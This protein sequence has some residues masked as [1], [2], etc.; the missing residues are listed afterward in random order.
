L[1]IKHIDNHCSKLVCHNVHFDKRI[2]SNELIRANTNVADVETYCTMKQTIN[3]FKI[4]PKVRGECKWPSLEQLY[5]KCF[6][7]SLENAHNSYYDVSHT[8]K[9]YFAVQAAKQDA[10]AFVDQRVW[11][12]AEEKSQTKFERYVRKRV[13]QRKKR[14]RNHI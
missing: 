8:A 4:T 1:N 6:N 13:S 7:E 9:C 2:V 5:R 3:C 10:Q 11:D 12:E 14:F